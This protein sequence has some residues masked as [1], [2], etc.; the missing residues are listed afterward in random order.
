M[1]DSKLTPRIRETANVLFRIYLALTIACALAYWLA[2]MSAFDAISHSFSTVSIGGFSTHD[3]SIGYFD[4]SAIMSI[5]AFFMVVAG[6]NARPPFPCLARSQTVP[7]LEDPE[8]DVYLPAAGRHPD[9]LPLSLLQRHPYGWDESVRQ[10][11]F[12][13]ISIMTTTGFA[14]DASSATGQPSCRSS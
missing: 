13:L 12:H 2:G 9:H 6:I 11:R 5:C 10:G 1:K 4:S 14:T 7:L 8:A 3:Q